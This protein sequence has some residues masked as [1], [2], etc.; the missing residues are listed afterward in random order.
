[1]VLAGDTDLKERSLSFASLH[2][3]YIL[4]CYLKRYVMHSAMLFPSVQLIHNNYCNKD[5]LI[6]KVNNMIFKT[7]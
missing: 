1:M 6:S 5:K 3:T 4:M 2:F 7:S